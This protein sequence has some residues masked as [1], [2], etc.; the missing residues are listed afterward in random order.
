MTINEMK[1]E[2]PVHVHVETPDIVTTGIS[3]TGHVRH[4]NEDSIWID[5]SGLVLAVAD[6][7]GG[8]DEV[9]RR[10]KQP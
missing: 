2:A 3:D 4:E 8:H 5:S 7:M 6:G 1:K 9:L 10:V